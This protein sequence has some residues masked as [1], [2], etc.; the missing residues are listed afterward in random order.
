MPRVFIGLGSNLGNREENISKAKKLLNDSGSAILKE[1]S[2]LET[3]PVIVLDQPKFF[4]QIII[5][6]TE[7]SPIKLLENLKSIEISIG[8]IK[9]IPKGP[10]IIDI[11][12]L[13]YNDHIIDKDKLRI[14]H[15]EIKNRK[16]ILDHLAE[17]DPDLTDPI[18]G[19]KY[20]E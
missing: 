3:D 10:R 20:T 19:K 15:P 13:L 11:D 6:E 16:F 7:L 2:I 9:T 1:S 14:P 8:R 4:N 5:I 18:T 17:L 12:I